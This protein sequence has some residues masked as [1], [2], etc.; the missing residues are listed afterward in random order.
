MSYNLKN[1][2]EQGASNTVIGGTIEFQNPLIGNVANVT[3]STVEGV[4]SAVNSILT[5]LKELNIM[6]ADG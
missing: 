4:K 1:Y 6:E 3:V 2:T 5:K